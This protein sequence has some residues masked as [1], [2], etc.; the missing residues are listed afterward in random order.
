MKT[1]WDRYLE[2][3]LADP[4]ACQVYE[5]EIRLLSQQTVRKFL[6]THSSSSGLGRSVKSSA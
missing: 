2:Q 3:Q 6:E 4:A 5:K 1:A